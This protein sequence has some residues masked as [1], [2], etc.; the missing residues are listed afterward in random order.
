MKIKNLFF[1]VISIALLSGN[2][3]H[4]CDHGGSSAG[5]DP[6]SSWLVSNYG[7]GGAALAIVAVAPVIATY[8]KVAISKIEGWLGF[9][10]HHHATN[11]H[12]HLINARTALLIEGRAHITD[13]EKQL[14][15][16]PQGSEQHTDLVKKLE[17]IKKNQKDLANK[18]WKD[19]QAHD[20]APAS[21]AHTHAHDH[22]NCN[23]ANA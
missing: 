18:Q 23:H 7:W 17:K 12:P 1:I 14:A 10:H 9:G 22:T 16:A 13:L 3:A 19:V 2:L 20:N 8:N 5:G 6:M 11:K 4:G 21:N 15:A